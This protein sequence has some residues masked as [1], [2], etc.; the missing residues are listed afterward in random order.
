MENQTKMLKIRPL[1][2]ALAKKA[3][4]ELHEK[5]NEIEDHVNELRKWVL[6]QPH[7]KARTGK[8]TLNNV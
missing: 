3:A 2:R 7:L 5:P 8:T 4:E 6:Q 1:S